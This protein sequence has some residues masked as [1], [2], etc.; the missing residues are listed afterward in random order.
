MDKT[1]PPTSFGVFNPV[2]HIVIAYR[3]PADLRAAVTALG[4]RGIGKPDWVYYTP[5]EMT[6]QV[7]KQLASASALASIG[8]DLNLIKA[9]RELA[10]NGCS[11]LVVQAPDDERAER[12]TLVARATNAV[13]AQRYGRFI[14]EE[15]IDL[16]PG[17]KQVFESPDRGLD[18]DVNAEVLHA[19]T[20]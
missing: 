14:V 17:Q 19:E 3:S 2:G 6:T 18:M 1:D 10:Q 16:P 5:E 4:E 15:L 13:A 8:Q 11:F 7:D 20:R 9:H 12:V